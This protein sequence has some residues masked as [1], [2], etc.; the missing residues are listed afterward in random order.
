[1]TARESSTRTLKYQKMSLEFRN[2]NSSN[3]T[4]EE[5]V[6]Q[7]KRITATTIKKSKIMQKK[8]LQICSENIKITYMC[9]CFSLCRTEIYLN[10]EKKSFIFRLFLLLFRLVNLCWPDLCVLY[11]RT[12]THFSIRQILSSWKLCKWKVH[13][14]Q[15]WDGF[16]Y[17]HIAIA[18]CIK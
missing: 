11:A 4:E 10:N 3:K 9:F 12:S 1:M 16:G 2:S 7:Q 15:W 5:E 17:V 6:F 13:G 8:R 18:S 14:E